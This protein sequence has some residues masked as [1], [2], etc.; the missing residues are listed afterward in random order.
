MRGTLVPELS[1][2]LRVHQTR[3]AGNRCSIVYLCVLS[4]GRVPVG[5]TDQGVPLQGDNDTVLENAVFI[6]QSY[7]VL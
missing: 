3:E 4:A 7:I 6:K 5:Q 1:R 2:V